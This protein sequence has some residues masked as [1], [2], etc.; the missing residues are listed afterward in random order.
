MAYWIVHF[1][2]SL[3]TIY[4]AL[5][6]FRCK[7]L[8]PT[9]KLSIRLMP[10]GICSGLD[11]WR[12]AG[13]VSLCAWAVTEI[14]EGRVCGGCE[15]QFVMKPPQNGALGFVVAT[16]KQSSWTIQL[17]YAGNLMELCCFWVVLSKIGQASFVTW[18]VG[19]EIS[20]QISH[21]VLVSL[22]STFTWYV[23]AGHLWQHADVLGAGFQSASRCYLL[24]AL[25]QHAIV[26]CN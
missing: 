22:L 15:F 21:I 11:S 3:A 6:E 23:S 12:F 14:M 24:S 13:Y 25:S 4:L 20:T 7:S 19:K 17:I 5:S 1:T 10:P 26:A 16:I 8:S 2:T 18:Q 9:C